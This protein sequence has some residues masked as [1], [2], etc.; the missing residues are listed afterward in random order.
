[1]VSQGITHP[2]G[3]L[4]SFPGKRRNFKGPLY[5]IFKTSFPR[6]LPQVL[7]GKFYTCHIIWPGIGVSPPASSTSLGRGRGGEAGE[8][9]AHE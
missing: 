6:G 5:P 7:G 1:M 8:E 3:A 4:P 2:V 9:G